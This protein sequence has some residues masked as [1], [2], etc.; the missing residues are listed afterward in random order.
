M[1]KTNTHHIYLLS[2]CYDFYS[3]DI[4]DSYLLQVM[5]PN[6]SLVKLL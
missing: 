3:D 5:P 6:D 4:A 2:T 1:M